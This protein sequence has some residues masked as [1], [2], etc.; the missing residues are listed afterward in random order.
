M[1]NI[2]HACRHIYP[3][4]DFFSPASSAFLLVSKDLLEKL[5][6]WDMLLQKGISVSLSVYS[7]YLEEYHRQNVHAVTTDTSISALAE[8]LSKPSMPRATLSV[9]PP[10]RFYILLLFNFYLFRLSCF[11]FV[12]VC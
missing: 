4:D 2:E 10:E 11:F 5:W 7:T 3:D 1:N 8:T 12:F 6:R 9:K